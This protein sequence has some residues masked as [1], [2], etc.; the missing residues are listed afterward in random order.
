[1]NADERGFFASLTVRVP[2]VDFEV[3]NTLGA[4]FSGHEI[5]PSL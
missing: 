2:G 3:S 1:M 5:Y 4:D